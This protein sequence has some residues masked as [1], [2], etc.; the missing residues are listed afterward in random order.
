MIWIKIQISPLR[1]DSK[2]FT[3]TNK[4]TILT[5]LIVNQYN[6]GIDFFPKPNHPTVIII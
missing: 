3:H 4:L 1:S 6:H 2:Q 5:Y